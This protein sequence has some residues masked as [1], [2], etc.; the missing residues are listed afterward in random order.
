[1]EIMYL[2]RETQGAFRGDNV[3]GSE[4]PRE[5]SVEIMYLVQRDPGSIPWR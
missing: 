5:H 4:R 2:F 3:P 1:M